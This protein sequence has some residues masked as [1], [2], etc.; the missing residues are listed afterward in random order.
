MNGERYC[1]NK[2]KNHKE[3]HDLD[4]EKTNCQVDEIIDAGNDV[5]FDSLSAAHDDSYDNCAYC[6]GDSRR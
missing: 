2:D 6:L 3:V 1:A 4:N 5:P